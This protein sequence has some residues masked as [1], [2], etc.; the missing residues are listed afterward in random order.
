MKIMVIS[1]NKDEYINLSNH[2][3][4]MKEANTQLGFEVK[5]V[6]LS[7]KLQTPNLKTVIAPMIIMLF[8]PNCK[9]YKDFSDSI[10]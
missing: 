4:K 10:I 8:Q 6:L 7:E 3:I 1:Q 2:I 9:E 5:V